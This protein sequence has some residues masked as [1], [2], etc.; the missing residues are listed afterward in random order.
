[1]ILGRSTTGTTSLSLL[2]KASSREATSFESVPE[3][4]AAIEQYLA[5]SNADPKP[6]VWP[7][8]AQ[9]IL[10]KLAKCKATYETL[11]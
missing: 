1:M 6:F 5:A 9:A 11:E 7:T 2:P 10:D 8:S 4:I 3:L